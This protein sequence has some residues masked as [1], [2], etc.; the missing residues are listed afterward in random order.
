MGHYSEPQKR[1][2]V[3]VPI[4]VGKKRAPA[5]HYQQNG[6]GTHRAL[7]DAGIVVLTTVLT[8][9]LLLGISGQ[10][11]DT[12]AENLTSGSP[13]P[14]L[15]TPQPLASATPTPQT[16]RSLATPATEDS[17][18]T[19]VATPDD[20]EIQAA[21]DKKL[22]DDA[23]LSQLGITA[24]VTDGTVILVGT[25]PSDE[26]KDKVEKLVHSVKGVRKIDNQIVVIS[27]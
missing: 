10:I 1:R 26:M 2:R 16:S 6:D 24:T 9:V 17:A 23:S 3:E 27:Q 18:S 15:L 21:I 12:T 8:T 4:P 5:R 20:T 7:I 11:Q 14:L 25:A 22:G 19:P 13:A